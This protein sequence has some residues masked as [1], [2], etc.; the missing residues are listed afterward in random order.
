MPPASDRYRAQSG[1]FN[2]RPTVRPGDAP[3]PCRGVRGFTEFQS[4]PDREAGRCPC[5]FLQ[6]LVCKKFQSTPDREAGRCRL[7][8]VP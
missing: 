4:T 8:G 6:K 3:N 2:P 5:E 1:C 7:A